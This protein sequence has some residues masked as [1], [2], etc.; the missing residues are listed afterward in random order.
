MSK[1]IINEIS[2]GSGSSTYATQFDRYRLTQ[3]IKFPLAV[4]EGF[5]VGYEVRDAPVIPAGTLAGITFLKVGSIVHMMIP[6]FHGPLL[7]G[8]STS[9]MRIVTTGDIPDRFLPNFRCSWPV[10]ALNNGGLINV[11]QD[12]ADLEIDT[13]GN[14]DLSS[15][16]FFWDGNAGINN[17]L[18]VSYLV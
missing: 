18:H 3:E 17:D 7:F 4:G 11:S 1:N 6:A 10:D 8:N 16:S 14:V 13:S 2:S 9:L 5:G 15:K 12:H